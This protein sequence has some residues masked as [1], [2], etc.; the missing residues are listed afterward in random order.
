MKIRRV[1][2]LGGAL[3]AV[4]TSAAACGDDGHAATHASD[5]GRVIEIAMTDMAYDPTAIA[6][7][8]GETVTFR[9]RNGGQVV[10]EAVIGDETYQTAHGTSMAGTTMAGMDDG[11]GMDHGGTGSTTA[12][13]VKPGKSADL[14]YRFDQAGTMLIGCHQPGHYEAGMKAVVTVS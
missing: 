11:H 3:A 12:V 9:L 14:T 10:H 6:V 13:T 1:L 8:R 7:A 4:A 2:A 5:K